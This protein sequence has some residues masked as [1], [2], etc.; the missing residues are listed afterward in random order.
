[1]KPHICC[2]VFIIFPTVILSQQV[3]ENDQVL[4]LIANAGYTGET[5]LTETDDGYLIKI[6]R[7]VP[8]VFNGQKPVL[9]MHGIL[10]T[11]ADFLITGPNAAL[12]YLLSDQGYDVYMGKFHFI[13]LFSMELFLINDELDI[14]KR[15]NPIQF[16]MIENY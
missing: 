14:F 2:F 16:F 1:M 11:A 15:L 4:Q 8:K 9:L 10:A 7:I 5:H 13:Y 12:A 3:S 6:H